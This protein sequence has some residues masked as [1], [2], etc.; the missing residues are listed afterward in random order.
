MF[1]KARLLDVMS[2]FSFYFSNFSDFSAPL[3][4]YFRFVLTILFFYAVKQN[5]LCIFTKYVLEKIRSKY[6][7]KLMLS[8]IYNTHT[9][10]AKET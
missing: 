8:S 2:Y 4:F 5:N 6:N 1:Q 9:W 7:I 3:S 10:R